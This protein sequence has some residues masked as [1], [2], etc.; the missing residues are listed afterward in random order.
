MAGSK[1]LDILR[2]IAPE[3]K[4]VPDEEVEKF[5]GLCEPM[6]SKSK[7]G[8]LYDQAVALLTAHRMK[9]AGFGPSLIGG[10]AGSGAATAGFQLASVGEGAANVSFNTANINAADDSWYALTPYGMEYLDLRR[11]CVVPITIANG[12]GH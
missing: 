8:K 1:A 4:G 10:A 12:G 9:L 6:V 3:F 11:I 2:I 5:L 7:F